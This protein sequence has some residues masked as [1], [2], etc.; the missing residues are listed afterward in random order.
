[1]VNEINRF[2]GIELSIAGERVTNTTAIRDI[3][4]YTTVNTEPISTPPFTIGI[5]AESMEEARKLYSYLTASAIHDDFYID[6]L[7][8]DIS[9][10]QEELVLPAFD[11][12][13][14][15]EHLEAGEGE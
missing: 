7:T 2:N 11:G 14:N 8:I 15:M 10:P 4:G 5:T 3:N 1:L 13:I 12:K 9:E 6:D